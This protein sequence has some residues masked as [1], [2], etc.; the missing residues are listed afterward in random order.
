MGVA[1][2]TRLGVEVGV[3]LAAVVGEGVGVGGIGVGV[4]VL[5]GVAVGVGVEVVVDVRVGVGVSKRTSLTLMGV[6]WISDWL[7]ALPQARMGRSR[8]VKM[9]YFG[10]TKFS[11]NLYFGV[12]HGLIEN[13]QYPFAFTIVIIK[14]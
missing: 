7:R 10:F 1:V 8:R 14:N 9:M 11:W 12:C 5:V 13:I 3:E 2:G 4:D 6:D